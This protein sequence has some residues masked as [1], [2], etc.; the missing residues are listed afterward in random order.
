MEERYTE[1][2]NEAK[3]AYCYHLSLGL[4]QG[5][6]PEAEKAVN[7]KLEGFARRFA[8]MAETES[9]LPK[10]DDVV[11]CQPFLSEHGNLH[12]F[13]Y[14]AYRHDTLYS[15]VIGGF[16]VDLHTG[17]EA[18][19]PEQAKGLAAVPGATFLRK[20]GD[21]PLWAPM[22][23]MAAYSPPEDAV[24]HGCWL[25]QYL[26]EAWVNVEIREA[27]GAWV[28]ITVPVEAVAFWQ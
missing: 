20:D 14:E 9:M 16:I 17:E 28:R 7:E 22:E 4:D 6:S 5:Q 10:P 19:T 13:V 18:L 26:E 21:A 8:E 27:Q 1:I 2:D 3:R 25:D 24:V 23:P 15:P 12:S 11:I